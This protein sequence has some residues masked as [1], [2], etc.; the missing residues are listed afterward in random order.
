VIMK[1]FILFLKSIKDYVIHFYNC[2]KDEHCSW[3]G[4]Y[5]GMHNLTRIEYTETCDDVC[6]SC[7]HPPQ[8]VKF[9]RSK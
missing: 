9:I 2:Q 3:C 5:K 7:L 8:S 6:D 1:L 4:K